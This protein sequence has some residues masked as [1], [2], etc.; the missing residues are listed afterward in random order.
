MLLSRF[1]TDFN[2]RK[3]LIMNLDPKK[4]L[5]NEAPNLE[6]FPFELKDDEAVIALKKADSEKITYIKLSDIEIRSQLAL[7]SMP[8]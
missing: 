3:D 2:T 8:Q 1:S 7:P 4:E 6:E 5:P